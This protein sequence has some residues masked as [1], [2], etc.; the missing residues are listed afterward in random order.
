MGEAQFVLLVG[1]LRRS[2]CLKVGFRLVFLLL[3]VQY[4][5]STTQKVVLGLLWQSLPSRTEKCERHGWAL[6][7]TRAHRIVLRHAA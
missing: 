4:I 6:G 7:D 3:N 2:A 1:I 5:E